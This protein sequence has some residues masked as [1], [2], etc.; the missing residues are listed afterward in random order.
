MSEHKISKFFQHVEM[1]VIVIDK[2]DN[3][4]VIYE[5]RSALLM[6]NPHRKKEK[7]E[8]FPLSDIFV[9]PENDYIEIKKA[10]NEGNSVNG[11][12]TTLKTTE[13]GEIPVAIAA[14]SVELET[15]MYIVLY[16]SRD[17]EKREDSENEN[18]R[19]LAALLSIAYK[20]KDVESA[21]DAVLSFAGNY[22]NV[23]RTYI[24]ESI[25]ET[26]TANTYE[27]CA[28]GT[29]AAI[30]LLQNLPK[31]EY[32]YDE[33][34]KQGMLITNDVRDMEPEDQAV[35]E[36]QGVKALAI[37][38]I[39]YGGE[40]LGYVGFDDCEK[41]RMWTS[42]EIA[43]L[44]ETSAIIASLLVQRNTQKSLKY[45]LEIFQT[46]TDNTDTIIYVN[47][48]NSFELLFANHNLA[49]SIG[50]VKEKIVGKKCYEVIQADMKEQCD[51]CPMKKMIDENGVITDNYYRW[52]FRNTITGKWYLIR[53][54]IIKWTDGKYVHLETAT[55]ITNRKKYESHLEFIASTDV[56]T[57]AYTRDWGKKILSNILDGEGKDQDN[58]LIFIDLDGLKDVNDKYGHADG[59]FMIIKSLEIVKSN[60]RKSD[61]I[62]RWG[63]DEFVIIL[64]GSH[65][66]AQIVMKKVMAAI[67][68]YN[69]KGEIPFE[70]SFSYGIETVVPLGEDTVDTV[71]ARADKKM[72]ENKKEKK[73][74]RM[75]PDKFL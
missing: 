74:E 37:I 27:W 18:N 6:F 75:N 59:D 64:R 67:D 20:T 38:S 60:I 51:F 13:H 24:F 32:T 71:V 41:N 16:I 21:I 49:S 14:S 5:N 3:S 23:N 48:I 62:C 35:L 72:Y 26:L 12:I 25:S 17:F 56:M 73:K 11:Y 52:E 30:D 69:A 42:N 33:I 4:H 7:S 66:D 53:D 55:E 9:M 1:P 22:I 31:D 54:S 58:C 46:V 2:V 63:G 65:D 43:F 61:V 50:T 15:Q 68:N 39:Y 29:G 40:P 47:D 70:L 44:E 19:A 34:I 8:K 28:P 36:P 10:I 57:G 45:S